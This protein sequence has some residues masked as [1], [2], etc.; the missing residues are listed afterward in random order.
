MV[1]SA[2][3]RSDKYDKKLRGSVWNQRFTDLKPI[4]V[5]QVNARFAEQTMMENQIKQYLQGVG[6]YGIMQHHYMNYGGRLWA[7]SRTF[8]QVT[9][10]MEAEQEAAK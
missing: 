1:R 4:M 10:R 7:L 5:E 8:D 9:L 2:A 3:T 6:M